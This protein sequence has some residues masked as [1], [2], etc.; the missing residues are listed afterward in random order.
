[1]SSVA[2]RQEVWLD[3]GLTYG[4]V[5]PVRVHVTRRDG[6]YVFSDEGAA[7]EAAGVRRPS[8]IDFGKQIE[9]DERPYS[10]NVS[11]RGV[12]FVPAVERAGADWLVTVANIVAR[13]SRELYSALLVLDED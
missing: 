2:E 8:R 3:S 4:G 1:V 7:V 5:A 6:R 13:A 10:A 12:V 9:L 11:R